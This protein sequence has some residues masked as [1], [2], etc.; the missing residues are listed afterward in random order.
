MV[1]EELPINKEIGNPSEYIANIQVMAEEMIRRDRNHPC[2]ITWGIAGEVNASLSVAKRMV[3]AAARRY[4]ELDPTRPVA[5]HQPRGDEIEAL[6]DVVG[7]GVDKETDE[8]H[9]R[10][11]GR[12]Y[13]VAEYSAST[14]GRGIYGG[15][16]ESEELA[17]EKHAAYLGQLNL[18]PWMAGGMI[19]HQFDY[20]GETYD[21][22]IPHVVAFG[23][24]DLWRIPKDVYYFYQ[25]QWTTR[26]MVHIL[27]H[28]TWPG[29]EGKPRL[30]KVFSNAPLV[31]LFLNGRSLGVRRDTPAEGLLHPPRVWTV[32]Y[33]PGDLKAVVRTEGKEIADERRTAGNAHHITLV[34]DARELESGNPESLA[35]ITARVEDKAGTLVPTAQVPITFT[36]YGP[37]EILHQTWLGHGT[38]WTL[39]AVAGMTCVAFRAT[40]RTGHATISAYSPGLRMGR[41]DI[42]VETPR[43]P[44]EMEYQEKFDVDEP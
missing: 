23:M 43:K 40:D 33:Q 38:G 26:P 8:K 14:L 39:D 15:G 10:F 36:S 16:P 3:A 1:W 13:L 4:R 29:E 30:V 12:P 32:P 18:R 22:V 28:W 27:G 37:G 35:Y 34:A 5:M 11:P 42:N 31:E 24:G 19:W 20:E 7:L 2:I 9:R 21:T 6:V 44:D 17:C 41:I 25:S